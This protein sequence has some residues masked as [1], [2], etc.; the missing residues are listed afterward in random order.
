MEQLV[1][2]LNLNQKKKNKQRKYLEENIQLLTKKKGKKTS[3]L[4][5][6]QTDNS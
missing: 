2:S 5:K 1:Y 3:N 4:I 6:N